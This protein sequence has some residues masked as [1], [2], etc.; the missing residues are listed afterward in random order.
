MNRKIVYVD[1]D[2]VIANFSKGVGREFVGRN[3]PEM[4]E[5]GFFRNLEPMP[6][7]KESIG[8]LLTFKGLDVYIATK[9]T[10]RNLDCATE[11]YQWIEQ[12]FKP[13]LFKMF[14]TCDKGHLNGDYLIDDEPSSWGDKFKGTF[15]V[16]NELEP[17]LS[18]NRILEHLAEYK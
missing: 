7:A 10:T 8:E 4:F 11:K 18:W 12:H 3:P 16:F 6:F 17:E 14:L 15:L 13:L 5:K 1:M 2:G 9:P